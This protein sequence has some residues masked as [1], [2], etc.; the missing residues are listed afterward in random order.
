MN[1]FMEDGKQ[2]EAN[3]G[4]GKTSEEK[5][6]HVSEIPTQKLEDDKDFQDSLKS[7]RNNTIDPKPKETQQSEA[8]RNNETMGIP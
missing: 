7:K 8:G 6:I 5:Y 3:A 2:K 4:N 1:Y